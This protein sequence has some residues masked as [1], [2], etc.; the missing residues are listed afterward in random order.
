MRQYTRPH[1]P[2]PQQQERRKKA[3]ERRVSELHHR[4]QH[5]SRQRGVRMR[6]RGFIE[7]VDVCDTEVEWG[8]ED[9]VCGWDAGEEVEGEDGGAE[10]EFFCYGALGEGVSGWG[11]LDRMRKD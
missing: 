1:V 7:M 2:R 9:E 11:R 8:Q 10:D 3:K 4:P 6:Q 5:D